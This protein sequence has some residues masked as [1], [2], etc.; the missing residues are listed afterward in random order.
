MPTEERTNR[1]YI[2]DEN[3]KE[4]PAK[5]VIVPTPGPSI[6]VPWPKDTDEDEKPAKREKEE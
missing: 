5:T 2:L 3:G 1:T 4:I 6:P